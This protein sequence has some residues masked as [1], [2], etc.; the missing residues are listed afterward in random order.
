MEFQEVMRRRKSTRVYTGE[1]VTEQ[2]IRDILE[3]ALLAPSSRDLLPTDF[4]A[5]TDPDKLA[6]LSKVKAAGGIRDFET[7]AAMIE[8]GAERLGTS[9]G[10]ELMKHFE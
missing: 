1:P 10:V 3:A 2:E 8:A 4:I 6:A 9:A 5:V 7:A